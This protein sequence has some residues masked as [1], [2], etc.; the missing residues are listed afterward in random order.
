MKVYTTDKIRN[1]AVL[2]HGGGAGKALLIS[3]L[4]SGI[5]FV[6]IVI[7]CSVTMELSGI[8]VS[9]SAA[10]VFACFLSMPV[11]VRF[12]KHLPRDESLDIT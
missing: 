9:Q 5:L 2:G 7:L 10:N 4:R 6:P 3:S 1:V 8:E 12:L 11:V